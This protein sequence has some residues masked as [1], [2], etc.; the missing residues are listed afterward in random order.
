[1]NKRIESI[2][3]LRGLM[4]L[5]MIVHHSFYDIVAFLDAPQEVFWNPWI[6][7]LHYIVAIT[8]ILLA[9]VSSRFSRNNIKRGLKTLA[10]AL[11][12]T[13]VLALPFVNMPVWFGVLHLLAVCM[14]AYGF[15]GKYIDRVHWAVWLVLGVAA[16]IA[17]ICGVLPQ[18]NIYSSDW[19]PPV[20]WAFAF[21]LGT[22][23]GGWIREDKFP[24][25]F[26]NMC[27]PVLPAIGRK[28]LIIYL[29]H[30]PLMFGIVQLIVKFSSGQ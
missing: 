21:L 3:A 27:V 7:S 11:L 12:V 15:L 2:D 6:D 30:Q 25:W 5:L 22:S 18:P 1:M 17:E 24:K 8:F 23:V 9:G 19:F 14:I 20:P 10:C 26:Y 28:A 4:V 13:I 29:V 16:F